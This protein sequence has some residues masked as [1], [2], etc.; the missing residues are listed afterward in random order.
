MLLTA[1]QRVIVKGSRLSARVMNGGDALV[2]KELPCQSQTDVVM[3]L[4][5]CSAP[6]KGKQ[7][8]LSDIPTCFSPESATVNVSAPKPAKIR[9]SVDLWELWRSH[10]FLPAIFC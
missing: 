1:Q 3:T 7:L 8:T 2:L 5:T 9:C 10:M 4:E 6:L